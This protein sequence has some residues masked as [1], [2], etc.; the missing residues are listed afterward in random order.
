MRVRPE[1]GILRF[2]FV[3][4]GSNVTNFLCYL[5]LLSVHAPVFAA[6]VC[7]YLIG[8]VCSYHFGRTW[9]F[10]RR[11]NVSLKNIARFLVVYFVGGAG[12]STITTVLVDGL[13]FNYAA[14]WLIGA[15]F[16][17]CNNFIGL[18]FLVFGPERRLVE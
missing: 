14:G 1:R 18:K 15:G 10:G 11:F 4:V 9:V 7:G 5:A 6:A 12:M 8:L 13:M 16:A 3:G 17:A 2:L